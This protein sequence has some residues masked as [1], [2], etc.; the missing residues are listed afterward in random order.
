MI[1]GS[2]VLHGANPGVRI[3]PGFVSEA[4]AD[5]LV[6]EA[7]QAASAYRYGYDGDARAFVV[8]PA[9]GAIESP[10]EEL[11][12]NNV[13]VTG[14]PKKPGVQRLPPWGYGDDFDEA[15]LPLVY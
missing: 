6:A 11:V 4:D 9:D 13:R 12:V 15:A 14:R 8:D 2:F 5:A 10:A 1:D 7:R 3:E